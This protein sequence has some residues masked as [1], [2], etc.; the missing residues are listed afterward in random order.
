MQPQIAA[1]R[2]AK[3]RDP[4]VRRG[5]EYDAFYQTL[6]LPSGASLWQVEESAR[7]LRTAFHPEGAP[8]R[9]RQRAEERTKA[10]DRAA[11]ELRY[12][13][14]TYHRVPPSADLSHAGG[15]LDALVEALG[16]SAVA[17]ADPVI[18][19]AAAVQARKSAIDGFRTHEPS[20]HAELVVPEHQQPAH[21]TV[22]PPRAPMLPARQLH[23]VELAA[24]LHSEIFDAV[25]RPARSLVPLS[26][27]P[28]GQP[29]SIPP[30]LAARSAPVQIIR[31]CEPV[32]VVLPTVPPGYSAA[33]VHIRLDVGDTVGV[34]GR[35]RRRDK[36]SLRWLAMKAGAVGVAIA[37]G[38]LL[39]QYAFGATAS[40]AAR[41]GV[42]GL[43]S[44]MR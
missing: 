17:V 25:L 40:N 1:K 23:R 35:P 6:D 22:I 20:D 3:W 13:W 9:L 37:F 34:Q 7:L 26:V 18:A 44:P 38:M 24:V 33:A 43:V 32:A 14:R 31:V 21:V 12:F 16:E 4:R 29:A 15:L 2:G 36:P 41:L 30:A 28:L 27:V 11:K 39:H 8:G 5:S 19:P 42:A 10:I